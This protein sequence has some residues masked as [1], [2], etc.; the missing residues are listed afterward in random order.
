MNYGLYLSAG[1]ALTSMHRQD[2][3]ANNLAN[4]NTVGF[5]PD[6]VFAKSR[7]PERLES[8]TA[9]ADP[10]LLLEQLGGGQHLNPTFINLAQ[11]DLAPTPNTLDLAIQGE[12]FFA[13]STGKQGDAIRLTRDGRFSMNSAGD[14]VM[15]TTGMKVLDANDQPI[16]LDRNAEVRIDADGGVIQNGATIA[17]LQ[18]TTIPDTNLLAKEGDSLF[19]LSSA[20]GGRLNRQPASGSIKQGYVESSA[21]DPIL[22][23]N[24]MI[25]ASKAVQSN[26]LMM[27][28]H[29][30]LMG[31]AIN[32]FGRVG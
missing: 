2:V 17:Q 7:L 8:G 1:G 5:K 29:D 12:G 23:L 30:N 20:A 21:V 14:L 27:Q 9:M 4:V 24:E 10:Q 22:A 19:R 32:T 28:Y 26:A 3:I 31:Q 15:S 16:R 13:I 6:A 18:I 11:G 25:N